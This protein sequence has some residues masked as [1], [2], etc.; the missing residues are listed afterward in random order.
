MSRS[1]YNIST[2]CI[3]IKYIEH[4]VS[5]SFQTEPTLVDIFMSFPFVILLLF[6]YTFPLH[7]L[8]LLSLCPV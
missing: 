1:N 2:F 8:C 7:A 3:D 4:G 6:L 5:M